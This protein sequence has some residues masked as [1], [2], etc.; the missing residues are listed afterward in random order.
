MRD[1]VGLVLQGITK[2]KSSPFRISTYQ[3]EYV[4]VPSKESVAEYI[5]APDD[6]LNF[7]ESANDVSIPEFDGVTPRYLH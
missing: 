7:V 5:R 3:G 2:Y 4:L 6:V 1:P